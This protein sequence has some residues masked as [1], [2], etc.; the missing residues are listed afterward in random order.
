MLRPL[1]LWLCA[2]ARRVGD[3]SHA[4]ER[5][6]IQAP[7]VPIV[8]LHGPPGAGKT[9]GMKMLAVQSGLTPWK[10]QKAGLHDRT[11]KSTSLAH[12]I[13]KRIATL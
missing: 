7:G 1:G 11:F 10:L 6:A 3:R 9:F 13:P 4:P 12:A 8:L 2:W 5:P